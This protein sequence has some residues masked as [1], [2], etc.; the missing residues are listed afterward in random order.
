M[1]KEEGAAP[2]IKQQEEDVPRQLA[3]VRLKRLGW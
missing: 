3:A 1:S 2:N